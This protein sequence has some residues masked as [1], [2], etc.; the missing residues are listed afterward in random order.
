MNSLGF[1]HDCLSHRA[2]FDLHGNMTEIP[3]GSGGEVALPSIATVGK[4]CI[5]VFFPSQ[6]SC[7]FCVIIII[8]FIFL[9]LQLIFGAP[10]LD[11]L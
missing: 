8:L 5:V 3:R 11:G 1:Y 6:G 10:S 7:R 2:H 9:A 4:H